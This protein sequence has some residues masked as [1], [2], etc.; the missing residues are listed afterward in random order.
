MASKQVFF[1][2][3]KE[4]EKAFAPRVEFRI[5]ARFVDPSNNQKTE[6]EDRFL[7]ARTN[8]RAMRYDR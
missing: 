4:A 3:Y 5:M 7:W 6:V 1:F 8:H 2:P